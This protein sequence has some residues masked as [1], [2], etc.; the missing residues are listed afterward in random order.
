LPRPHRGRCEPI[1]RVG[2]P[3]PDSAL[4][5]TPLP[6]AHDR[7]SPRVYAASQLLNGVKACASYASDKEEVC[8]AYFYH[9]AVTPTATWSTVAYVSSCTHVGAVH[10]LRA[11]CSRLSFE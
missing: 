11:R 10:T 2:V 3:P 4:P 7:D 9:N 1:R 6:N 5:A 8:T